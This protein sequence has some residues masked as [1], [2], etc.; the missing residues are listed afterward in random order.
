[1]SDLLRID[2][3]SRES[4]VESIENIAKDLITGRVIVINDSTFSIIDIEI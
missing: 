2:N 4:I 3:T 1:M